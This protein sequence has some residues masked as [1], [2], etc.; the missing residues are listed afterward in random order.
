MLVV[1]T[2][3]GMDNETGSS[4]DDTISASNYHVLQITVIGM[5]KHQ[6]IRIIR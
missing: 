1:A 2:T 4:N 6:T 5:I 3:W